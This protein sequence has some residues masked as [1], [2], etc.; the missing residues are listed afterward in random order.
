MKELY[1]SSDLRTDNICAN[2]ALRGKC[3]YARDT[4]AICNNF[5]ADKEND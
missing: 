2:C 1:K 5:V 3:L 4:K